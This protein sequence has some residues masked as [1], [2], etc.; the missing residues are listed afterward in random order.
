MNNGIREFDSVL[1]TCTMQ[2]IVNKNFTI[3]LIN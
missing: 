2:I 1:K 3:V